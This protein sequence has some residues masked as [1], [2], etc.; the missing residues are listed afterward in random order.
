MAVNR[1]G[2][3]TG[4]ALIKGRYSILETVAKRDARIGAEGSTGEFHFEIN[5]KWQRLPEAGGVLQFPNV[6]G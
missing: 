5:A 4:A 6:G 2:E 3:R 1:F